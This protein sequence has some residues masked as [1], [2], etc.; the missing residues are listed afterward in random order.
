MNARF[1]LVSDDPGRFFFRLLDRTGRLL[2]TGLP[3]EGKIAAQS[4]VLHARNSIRAADRFVSHRAD[5]GSHFVVLKDKDGSVLAKSATM[6]TEAELTALIAQATALG[7]AAPLV[8]L[9]RPARGI[10]AQG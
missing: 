10:A 8:D 7:G 6:A 9:T 4:E 1:E 2:L 5:D 3:C